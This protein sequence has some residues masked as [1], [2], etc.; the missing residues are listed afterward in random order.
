MAKTKGSQQTI[1]EWSKVSLFC[2]LIERSGICNTICVNEVFRNVMS[3][4]PIL[5]YEYLS[6]VENISTTIKKTFYNGV[7][8]LTLK[9]SL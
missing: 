3:M 4:N 7:A 5:V 8:N 6:K 2:E 9:I 1:N